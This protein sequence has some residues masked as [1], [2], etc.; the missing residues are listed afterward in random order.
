MELSKIGFGSL[1][2]SGLWDEVSESQAISI[3]N[4]ALDKGINWIDTSP[5]YGNGRAEKIIAE[6]AK[7]RRDDFF[8]ANKCGRITAANGQVK[9]NLSPSALKKELIDTL[10]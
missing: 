7:N 2:I 3:I 4:H 9:I 8:I 5:L 6:V 10:K 1:S